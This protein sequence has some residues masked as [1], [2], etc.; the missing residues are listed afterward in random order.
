MFKEI[1]TKRCRLRLFQASDLMTFSAYRADP[2]VARYQSWSSYSYKDAITFFQNLSEKPFGVEGEWYQIALADK[3]TDTLIG[4]LAVH[5][6]AP[7]IAE[8]GFTIASKHQRK[9]Y[10]K[11]GLLGLLGYLFDELGHKR[12]LATTDAKNIASMR[13]LESVGFERASEDA[14]KVIF[15]GEQGEEFDYIYSR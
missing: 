7:E 6:V 9:G 3:L 11:E 12:I 5:F 1:E 10:A 14:R 8:V 2:E 4:D 13:L 15:K